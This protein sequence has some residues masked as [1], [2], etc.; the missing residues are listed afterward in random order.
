MPWQPLVKCS[1]LATK[2]PGH[3]ANP[4]QLDLGVVVGLRTCMIAPKHGGKVCCS[5]GCYSVECPVSL[6]NESLVRLIHFV[7]NGKCDYRVI[8]ENSVRGFSIPTNLNYMLSRRIS[9]ISWFGLKTVLA[10]HRTVTKKRMPVIFWTS[11]SAN[12]SHFK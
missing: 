3:I 7:T 8:L 11:H 5:C 10:Y 2:F 6:S 9:Q 4:S 12:Q 1:I